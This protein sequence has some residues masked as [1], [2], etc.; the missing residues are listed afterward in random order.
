[1]YV[2]AVVCGVKFTDPGT[3]AEPGGL[4]A[5][6]PRPADI[7]TSAAVPERSAALDVCVCVASIA[8]AARGDAAQAAFDRKLSQ[9]RNEIGEL[10]QQGTHYRPLV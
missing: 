1:M 6:Q 8:A 9:Y 3:T 2:R 7:F 10:R 5:S 4:T